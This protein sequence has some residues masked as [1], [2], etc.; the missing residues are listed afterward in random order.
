MKYYKYEEL[1]AL[2]FAQALQEISLVYVPVGSLEFH[3]PHLPLGMDTI[4]AY[5]FCMQV[6][7]NTGGIVLPPSYWGAVGHDAWKGSLLISEET[8]RALMHDVF[9]LLA[10]Q[11]VK[12]IIATTGHHP[13]HQGKTIA[14]IAQESMSKNPSTRILA[15]DPY[16]TNPNDVK[17]DHA[18]KKET[19]LMLAI[20][21]E[22]VHMNELH[23]DDTFKGIGEDCVDGTEEFGRRYIKASVE[24]CTFIVKEAWNDLKG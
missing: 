13:S 21:P 9:R 16:G 14:E 11:G 10:E 3:G 19:S 20:R 4:H 24:N 15:L 17:A 18:G 6:A 23:G 7:R 2:Q 1:S 5:E 12:L 22:L 8:F